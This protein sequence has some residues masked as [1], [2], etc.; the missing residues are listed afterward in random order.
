MAFSTSTSPLQEANIFVPVRT[1]LS[2]GITLFPDLVLLATFRALAQATYVYI[3]EK[4]AETLLGKD[5]P[6]ASARIKLCSDYHK[7][8]VHPSLINVSPRSRSCQLNTE[9]TN[10]CL[11]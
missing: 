6:G 1:Y 8:P 2:L 10:L 3:M 11:I 9:I 4:K 7:I 5:N